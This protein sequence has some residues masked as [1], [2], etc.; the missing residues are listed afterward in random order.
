MASPL[1]NTYHLLLLKKLLLL[2]LGVDDLPDDDKKDSFAEKV[3]IGLRSL[4]AFWSQYQPEKRRITNDI[5]NPLCNWLKKGDKQ[6]KW[7]N[8]ISD[9]PCPPALSKIT[10]QIKVL[11]KTDVKTKIKIENAVNKNLDDIKKSIKKKIKI[12]GSKPQF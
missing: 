11:D 9:Y 7:G 3:G 6:Y 4:Q 12:K 1:R 8:F 10:E 5:L 2:E